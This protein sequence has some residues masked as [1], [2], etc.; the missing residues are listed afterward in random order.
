[1]GHGTTR[2]V[3][4]ASGRRKFL[5]VAIDYFTKWTEAEPLAFITDKH[6]Q[7][8]IWKNIITRFGVPRALVSDNGRQ[9]MCGPTRDYC[10]PFHI[11]TKFSVVSRTQT[12]GQ[13]ESANKIVLKGTKKSLETAKGAWVDD[14]LRVLWSACTTTKEATRHFLF[15]LV[16][17]SEAVLLVE[18][19]IPSPRM[20]FY[21]F[22]KND[23]E[24]PI[25]LD[26]L[27]ETRGNALL[28]SIRYK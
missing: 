22:E 18:V 15:G 13:V 11:Q 3:P 8:F 27:P 12:N 14:L 20:K 4:P 26:L 9:F 10:A 5:I 6:I 17:G 24:K 25:H 19:D 7:A 28:Q 1:M 23:K 16:Y 21:D 2:T